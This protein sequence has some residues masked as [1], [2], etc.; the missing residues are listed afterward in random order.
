M[1]LLSSDQ[2]GVVGERGCDAWGGLGAEKRLS[3]KAVWLN[4]GAAESISFISAALKGFAGGG[5][6]E[7]K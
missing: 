2:F 5:G 3:E 7:Y 1:Q 6:M 4:F